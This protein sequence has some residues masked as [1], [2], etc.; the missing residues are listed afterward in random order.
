MGKKY[1]LV[2]C[3]FWWD[4]FFIFTFCVCVKFSKRLWNHVVIRRWWVIHGK[5]CGLNKRSLILF[6]SFSRLPFGQF[7]N[8]VIGFSVRLRVFFRSPPPFMFLFP[9]SYNYALIVR[10]W[11]LFNW[12]LYQLCDSKSKLLTCKLIMCYWQNKRFP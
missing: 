1:Y 2:A 8:C 7:F 3:N 12:I 9:S 11:M 6:C 10:D 5:I 4:I